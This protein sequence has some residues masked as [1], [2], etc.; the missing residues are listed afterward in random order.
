MATL[1]NQ[2]IP[3]LVEEPIPKKRAISGPKDE[4]VCGK[5]DKKD[6]KDKKSR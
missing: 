6:K 1:I 4:K 3:S 2:I 5:T